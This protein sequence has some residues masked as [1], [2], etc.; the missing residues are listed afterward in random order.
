[1]LVAGGRTPS[2]EGVLFP[3]MSPELLKV[4]QALLNGVSYA[5][6]FIACG[7]ILIAGAIAV[8]PMGPAGPDF[9]H[10]AAARL[11]LQIGGSAFTLML[12][13]LAGYIAFALAGRPGPGSSAVISR[14]TW[15][16]RTP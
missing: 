2:F 5:I 10:A 7:G 13:V 9:S 6:P 3:P 11:V 1:M 4:K 16:A 8:V 12:P 14:G 15:T